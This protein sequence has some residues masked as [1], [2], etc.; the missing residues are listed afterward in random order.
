MIAK[1]YAMIFASSWS[2]SIQV[3]SQADGWLYILGIEK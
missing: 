2:I 3:D 1:A